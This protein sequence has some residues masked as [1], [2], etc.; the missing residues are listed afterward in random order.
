MTGRALVAGLFAALL[1]V[2]GPTVAQSPA[3]TVKVYKSP[4]CGCC[5]KWVKHLQDNGFTTEVTEIADLTEIKKQQK[6][7]NKARSCHTAT[8]GGYVLE[9]HVPAADVQ[10]LLKERPS[11]LGLAVPGMPIGSPGMEVPN[12]TPK[13]YNVVSFDEAGETQ[14]FASH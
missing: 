4:T 2:S 9:G 12:M 8:V 3:P 11:I 7:P 1:M 10:R 13:P 14:V 5:A 6:V